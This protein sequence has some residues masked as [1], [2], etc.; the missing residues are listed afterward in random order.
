MTSRN[1]S[2]GAAERAEEE[3]DEKDE[4]DE[5]KVKAEVEVEAKTK[6]MS[7]NFSHTP[8]STRHS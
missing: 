8:L 7:P 5:K 1:L 2:R 3:K 4:K 6:Q